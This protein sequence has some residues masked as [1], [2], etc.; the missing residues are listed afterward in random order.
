[1]FLVD[2]C[3]LARQKGSKMHT[4]SIVNRA[5]TDPQTGKPEVR[6]LTV[7]DTTDETIEALVDVFDRYMQNASVQ[8]AVKQ[9]V[10][11]IK[12][13]DHQRRLEAQDRHPISGETADEY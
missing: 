4:V 10:N 1:M 5:R 13:A 12:L 9:E 3:V 11:A 7:Y 2:L 6:N 8:E